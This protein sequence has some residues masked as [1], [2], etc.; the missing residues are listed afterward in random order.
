[1]MDPAAL[2]KFG[3]SSEDMTLIRFFL[4]DNIREV[5]LTMSKRLR[6]FLCVSFVLQSLGVRSLHFF[7]S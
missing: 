3:I 2:T 7:I 6:Y 4:F 5:V 1:M